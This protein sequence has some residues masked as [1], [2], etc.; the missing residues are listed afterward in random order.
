MNI[1]SASTVLASGIPLVLGDL[2]RDYT[3]IPCVGDVVSLTCTLSV[4]VI[5]DAV[6]EWDVPDAS[7]RIRLDGTTSLPFVRDQYTVIS[8][9]FDSTSSMITSSL[10]FPAAQDTTI[11][12][13]PVFEMGLREELTILTAS[14]D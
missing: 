4:S 8:A 13:F 5:D 12:C 7:R 9:V 11:G 3:G 6:L 1:M 2:T 10:R 14:E